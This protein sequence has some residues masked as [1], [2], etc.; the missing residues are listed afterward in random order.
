MKR[1][2]LSLLA[3]ISLAF[4][5]SACTRILAGGRASLHP[6]TPPEHAAALSLAQVTPASDTSTSELGRDRNFTYFDMRVGN[7]P[8]ERRDALEALNSV[9]DS[10]GKIAYASRFVSALEFQFWKPTLDTPSHR[11]YL[12]ALSL[13]EVFTQ[14][15]A[16]IKASAL[17]NIRALGAALH[18]VNLAQEGALRALPGTPETNLNLA[19]ETG[20]R[21]KDQLDSG[22]RSL[23][24]LRESEKLVSKNESI[25]VFL[26]RV[27]QN[28]LKSLGLSLAMNSISETEDQKEAPRDPLLQIFAPDFATR[29]PSQIGYI[30]RIFEYAKETRQFLQALGY[31]PKDEEALQKILARLDFEPILE[32]ENNPVKLEALKRLRDS[33]LP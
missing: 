21:A 15:K 28:A 9:P 30:A 10:S 29:D 33:L 32:R 26:L 17:E 24:T 31:D 16:W 25:A 22:A 2:A 8:Q 3:G 12:L 19:L 5:L 11:E 4:T 7:T 6:A 18:F 27:R 13:E 20:L 14:T 1:Q 23:E